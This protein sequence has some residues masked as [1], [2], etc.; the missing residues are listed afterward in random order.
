MRFV[1]VARASRSGF[2]N[3]PDRDGLATVWTPAAFDG[4]AH[5]R[6]HRGQNTEFVTDELRRYVT[7]WMNYFGISQTYAAVLE[8]DEWSLDDHVA[9]FRA[10]TGQFRGANAHLRSLT[11]TKT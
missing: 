5:I 9:F 10:Q 3:N 1:K 2:E 11:P 4:L 8:V 6:R 7:G